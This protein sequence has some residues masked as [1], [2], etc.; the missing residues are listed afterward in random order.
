M[1]RSP[2]CGAAKSVVEKCENAF[3]ISRALQANEECVKVPWNVIENK[4]KAYSVI[5]CMLLIEQT[6]FIV[7]VEFLW[8][9]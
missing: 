5:L 6:L 7:A 3:V 4:A 8:C 2:D 9:Y 1:K